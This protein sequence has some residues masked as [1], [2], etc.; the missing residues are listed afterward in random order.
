MSNTAR[1][2][3]AQ[4][5]IRWLQA[6]DYN[7]FTETSRLENSIGMW[8]YGKW[9][10]RGKREKLGIQ[11]QIKFRG[12]RPETTEWEGIPD[13]S[14]DEGMRIHAA[15]IGLDPR[16]IEIL[17]RVYVDWDPPHVAQ[18]KMRMRGQRFY[19]L[20]REALRH[21]KKVLDREVEIAYF[22]AK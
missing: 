15:T 9:C 12:S 2:I 19:Q 16:Q 11:P 13:I 1:D 5:L 7:R 4:E 10:A 3:V 20:R 17:E 8:E 14:D 22:G 21:M 6:E 18:R